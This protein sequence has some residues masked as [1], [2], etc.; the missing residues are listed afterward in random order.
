MNPYFPLI[1]ASILF[2][3]RCD[4]SEDLFKWIKMKLKSMLTQAHISY[5]ITHQ[6]QCSMILGVFRELDEGENNSF[7]R[8]NFQINSDNI[9]D[10]LSILNTFLFSEN[11]LYNCDIVKTLHWLEHPVC[12]PGPRVSVTNVIINHFYHKQLNKYFYQYPVSSIHCTI[13]ETTGPE[14]TTLE[15]HQWSRWDWWLGLSWNYKLLTSWSIEL[16]LLCLV[17]PSVSLI[18]HINWTNIQLNHLKKTFIFRFISSDSLK[19]SNNFKEVSLLAMWNSS[20]RTV[21]CCCCR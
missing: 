14:N 6:L 4:V 10:C 20:P 2:L 8:L 16:S 11:C 13:A 18:I 19:Q 17:R 1:D 7:N 3:N 5:L 15:W 9:K 21:H 12:G